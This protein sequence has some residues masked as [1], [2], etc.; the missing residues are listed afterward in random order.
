MSVKKV[1]LVN[2]AS[3]I[4]VGPNVGRPLMTVGPTVVVRNG[5]NCGTGAV[6]G[7][8][9]VEVRTVCRPLIEVVTRTTVGFADTD[10]TLRKVV[11]R[12]LIVVTTGSAE[13]RGWND[14]IGI[15]DSVRSMM[16]VLP[17]PGNLITLVFGTLVIPT[18]L[19]DVVTVPLTVLTTGTGSILG[20]GARLSVGP[21]PGV[22]VWPGAGL[23]L[24][25][26]ITNVKSAGL[27][28]LE[29]PV[30]FGSGFGFGRGVGRGP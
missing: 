22:T 28:V 21:G 1:V 6:V 24:V 5:V 8:K 30:V 27:K 14:V 26:I 3:V 19:V 11:G 15:R 20:S 23:E 13:T 18:K 29:D 12:P 16:V 25:G 2:G 7:R 10:M 9:N 4:T 17:P